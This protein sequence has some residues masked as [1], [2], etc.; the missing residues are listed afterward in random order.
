MKQFGKSVFGDPLVEVENI[1]KPVKSAETRL[2][3]CRLD[4]NTR[5]IAE[6]SHYLRDTHVKLDSLEQK[7]DIMEEKVETWRAEHKEMHR[8]LIDESLRQF[9]E[10]MKN[11]IYI[12]CQDRL[13]VE[14]L[15][16]GDVMEA[17]CNETERATPLQDLALVLRKY[18]EF[19]PKALSQ[20]NYLMATPKF[21]SWLTSPE[22][23]MLLVDGHCGDQTIGKIAPSSVFC[24]GLVE[25][26]SGP[27]HD[28]PLFS[29][30]QQPQV[31][32]HFFVGQHTNP[33]AG[34]CGPHGLVRSLIDQLLLQWP[35]HEPLDLT[36][37][38]QE[39]SG[40]LTSDDF[41]TR[42]LCYVFEQLVCQLSFRSPLFCVIDGLSHFETSL[43]GW[44]D[45]LMMIIDS[46][47]TCMH[48]GAGT[49]KFLL[50]SPERS[51]RVRHRVPENYHVDLRAG[52]FHARSPG[53]S[54]V[55]DMTEMESSWHNS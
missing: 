48:D 1:L 44:A 21:Q 27:L 15:F 25:A 35:Y 50:V 9:V 7:F 3:Q 6:S 28:P 22:S 2:E 54:L 51:T 19:S 42:F 20:A 34:L 10:D 39:F 31:V 29:L 49:V 32:L 46:F 37:L 12:A 38:E 40:R 33:R 24:S 4:L 13:R 41:E 47:F 26:L 16:S 18:H 55:V 36:F 8:S 45:D 17:I 43:W 14:W 23:G 30:P 53:Q 5:G 52:N 11:S